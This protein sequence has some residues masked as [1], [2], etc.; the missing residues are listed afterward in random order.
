MRDGT[1]RGRG[2]P[3]SFDEDEALDRITDLFWRRGFAATSLDELSRVSGV[4]RPSLYATFGS[5]EQMYLR[6]LRAFVAR[7][8]AALADAKS[9]G[10]PIAET[11]DAVFDGLLALYESSDPSAPG[12]RGCMVVCT[13]AAEAA[14]RAPVRDALAEVL[15][16]IDDRMALLL[17]AARERGQLA[18]DADVEALAAVLAGTAHSVALRA[19]AG[20]SHDSLVAMARTAVR[21]AVT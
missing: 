21:L 9:G 14:E 6:A 8:D 5:K 17:H 7:M 12:A 19:R 10:H 2:R 15:R 4:G 16:G 13:A 11:L 20:A 3:R 18:P 1:K